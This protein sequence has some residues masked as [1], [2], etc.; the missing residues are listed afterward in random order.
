MKNILKIKKLV[1]SAILPKRASHGAAGY[2]LFANLEEP[3]KIGP[4]QRLKV[5]TG[6]ALEIENENLAIFIFPRSGLGTKHGITLPNAVGVVDS[7]YR[8]EIFVA[9]TN[10]SDSEYFIEPDER[11]AQMVL[12]P[13]V[14][15][16][17]LETEEISSTKRGIGG[18]GSTGR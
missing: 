11:I 2:D 4:A 9:L 5:P 18:F 6:I 17:I 7:D 1:P 16:Q 14:H 3:L 10:I 8:G 15:P 12:M 13:V